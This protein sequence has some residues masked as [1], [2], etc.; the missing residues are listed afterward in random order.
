MLAIIISFSVGLNILVSPYLNRKSIKKDNTPDKITT[1]QYASF[2]FES[3]TGI[4]TS[5]I[6]ALAHHRKTFSGQYSDTW[7]L[8]PI[9]R[10]LEIL[11]LKWILSHTT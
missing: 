9:L 11:E 2:V 5:E 7:D 1:D 3:S 4:L 6:S 10:L 8:Q